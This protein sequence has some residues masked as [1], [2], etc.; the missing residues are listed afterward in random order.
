MQI[1]DITIIISGLAFI[2]SGAAFFYSVIRNH[3]LDA[4]AE[5]QDTLNKIQLEKNE[6]EKVLDKVSDLSA[7]VVSIGDKKK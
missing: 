6:K 7:E 1:N 5:R 3:K 2:L 4:F